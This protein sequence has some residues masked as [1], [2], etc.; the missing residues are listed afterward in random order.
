M[1]EEHFTRGTEGTERG[2]PRDEESFSKK[3]ITECIFCN[4]VNTSYA[5]LKN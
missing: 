4:K 1:G 5:G 2:Q 3:S